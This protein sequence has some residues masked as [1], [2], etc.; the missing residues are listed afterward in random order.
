M[1]GAP[2]CFD[3]RSSIAE[4]TQGSKQSHNPAPVISREANIF[5]TYR[6]LPATFYRLLCHN[7]RGFVRTRNVCAAKKER[8]WTIDETQPPTGIIMGRTVVVR[9]ADTSC[10]ILRRGSFF[11]NNRLKE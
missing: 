2:G 7:D 11:L 6:S 3:R 1:S 5:S 4:K 9:V 8:I 10:R